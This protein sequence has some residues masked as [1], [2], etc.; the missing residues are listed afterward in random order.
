MMFYFS[1][2]WKTP[3]KEKLI[4]E[5]F[6]YNAEATSKTNRSTILST[7]SAIGGDKRQ[8]VLLREPKDEQTLL[9]SF[10]LLFRSDND[11]I[12]TLAPSDVL[13]E[14]NHSIVFSFFHASINDSKREGSASTTP[15][16]ISRSFL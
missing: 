5:Q 3:V 9:H 14:C 2:A 15:K 8:L 12:E 1:F 10:Q 16:S 13:V 11:G 7:F 6:Y 4:I